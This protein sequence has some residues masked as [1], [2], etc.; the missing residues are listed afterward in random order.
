MRA[1]EVSRT[2]F[3]FLPVPPLVVAKAQLNRFQAE[4]EDEPD[5]EFPEW[6]EEEEEE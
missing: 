1:D 3:A 2:F 5:E 6:G 4:T